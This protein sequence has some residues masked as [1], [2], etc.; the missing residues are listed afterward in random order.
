MPNENPQLLDDAKIEERIEQIHYE[1]QKASDQ[2]KEEIKHQQEA[3]QVFENTQ[4]AHRIIQSVS[5]AI[6][7]EIHHKIASVVS[8]CLEAVFG[9]EAYQFDIRF[10]QKHGKTPAVL[11][12]KRNG[13]EI[14]PMQAAGG[15]VVDLVSMALRLV[16]LILQRPPLRR[17]LVLDEPAKHISREYRPAFRQLLETLAD[18]MGVQIIMVTHSSEYA[19]G[20]VIEL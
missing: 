17:I 9:E 15:G 5:Q 18:E 14:N 16:A 3:K 13:M 7:Q 1:Y 6:Q 12:L 4:E 2:V 10:E 8:R 20:K 19:T 11:L